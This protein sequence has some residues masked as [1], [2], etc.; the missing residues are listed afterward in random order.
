MDKSELKY[1][2]EVIQRNLP[3][4][5]SINKYRQKV[6]CFERIRKH[7]T[8]SDI[9]QLFPLTNVNHDGIRKRS[10]KIVLNLAKK[11]NSQNQLYDHLKHF[12]LEMNGIYFYKK[13]LSSDA[14]VGMLGIASMN[15]NGHIRERAL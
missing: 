12:P 9:F 8:P 13:N 7:A 10:V 4:F 3:P 2:I 6:D 14:F 15:Y 11:L 5:F 1:C